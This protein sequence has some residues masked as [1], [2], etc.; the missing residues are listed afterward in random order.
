M[1]RK[2]LIALA[3]VMVLTGTLAGGA[4]AYWTAHASGSG[5]ATVGTVSPV[6]VEAASGTPTSLLVPNGTADLLVQVTNPNA[7]AVTIVGISQSGTVSVTGGTGCTAANAG[8]TVPTQAALSVSIASGSHVVAHI[9][10][11]AAM[12]STSASGCQGAS[13]Q[14]PITLTVQR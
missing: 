13:F 5:T 14:I 4:Y 7:F 1:K 6:T 3:G 9:P 11:G 8:V 2:L 10:G 12:S